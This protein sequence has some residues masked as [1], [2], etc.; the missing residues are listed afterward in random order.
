[1]RLF[2]AILLSEELLD[3]LCTVQDAL[4]TGTARANF[5]R[6]ENLHLTLAFLGE[7]QNLDGA[8]RAG[9]GLAARQFPLRLRGAGSFSRCGKELFWAGVEES[10]ALTALRE[11]L[12]AR[13][14]EEG[15]RLEERPFLPHLTLA[16]DAAPDAPFDRGAFARLV[17]PVSMRVEAV[18]LMRS[19]RPGGVLTYTELFRAALRP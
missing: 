5:I 1:M 10:R 15:F 7:T 16:R 17:P 14:R 9:E 3:A 8:R 19:E 18:S 6:R 4:R 13:L 12:A 2:Y 11:E